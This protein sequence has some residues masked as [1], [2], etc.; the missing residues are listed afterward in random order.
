MSNTELLNKSDRL[1][2][3][4]EKLTSE[5]AADIWFLFCDR[6]ADAATSANLTPEQTLEQA[7]ILIKI[8]TQNFG[9]KDLSSLESGPNHW[10]DYL[11]GVKRETKRLELPQEPAVRN[12]I[13]LDLIHSELAYI[14]QN[15][16]QSDPSRTERDN[17][18]KYLKIVGG[19]DLPVRSID[20]TS[21]LF[22]PEGLRLIGKIGAIEVVTEE[23][24]R[25][26]VANIWLERNKPTFDYLLDD[27]RFN[28]F[29]WKK[30][31][32]SLGT[33]YLSGSFNTIYAIRT[34]PGHPLRTMIVGVERLVR[35]P[36]PDLPSLEFNQD[37]LA[38]VYAHEGDHL[39]NPSESSACMELSADLAKLE[40]F[41]LIEHL[42]NHG[43]VA[44]TVHKM[45]LCL[46]GKEPL[47]TYPEIKNIIRPH[48]ANLLSPTQWQ[49]L[50]AAFGITVSDNPWGYY[51][52][53]PPPPPIDLSSGIP[54]RQN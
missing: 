4:P 37:Y 36:N 28:N 2:Y 48:L 53:P 54:N 15:L 24:V 11:D 9:L 1:F 49:E 29:P 31:L 46:R 45:Y 39:Y 3:Q 34:I 52:P 17:S 26:A 47:S 20:L 7:L 6:F 33:I 38:G 32:E 41:R 51:P 50:F 19:R 44:N 8:V 30:G 25:D 10:R 18:I 13:L 42:R 21:Q 35:T 14:W 43:Y 23:G 27:P 16:S 22:E 12:V 40:Y 5:G